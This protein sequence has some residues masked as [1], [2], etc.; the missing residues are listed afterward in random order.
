MLGAQSQ[1]RV[2]IL[3][4]DTG[5]GVKNNLWQIDKMQVIEEFHLRQIYI[6]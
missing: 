6:I 3:K 1:T 2:E 4:L 5:F